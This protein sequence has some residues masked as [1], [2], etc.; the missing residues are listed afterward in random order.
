[1]VVTAGVVRRA[2]LQSKCHHQQ[3]NIQF[4]TGQMPFLHVW[5]RVGEHMLATSCTAVIWRMPS[6]VTYEVVNYCCPQVV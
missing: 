6:A 2:E 1:M 4:F 3:T 5:V